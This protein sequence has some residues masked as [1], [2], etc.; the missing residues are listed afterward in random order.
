MPLTE[1]EVVVY[2]ATATGVTAAVAAAR[3]GASVTLVE[4]GRHVGGM[5]SGGLSWTD[6]GDVR[7][8]GGL[9]AEFH[10]AVADAYGVP[11]WGV[12][13]PEPHVAEALLTGWLDRAG[14][15]V[16][17][18]G[19]LNQVGVA[20]G[21]VVELTTVTDR[22]RASVFVDASYEGD[23]L[24]GAGVSY[25]IGR[26]PRQLYGERWAGRQP[27]TRP[28]AHN[29]PLVL[30]PFAEDGTPYPHVQPP[31]VDSRGWT[32]D[33]LGAGDGGLQA[34]AFRVCLTDRPDNR[35][36]FPEPTG[37]DRAEFGLLDA[38]LSAWGER[39]GAP[40]LLGV[41]RRLLPA[42]KCDVNSIGPFSLNVLDGSNRAYPDGDA[43]VRA[44]VRARHLHYTQS[45]LHHLS[46]ADTVPAHIRTEMATWGLCADEFGDT[47]G[48]PHQLYV[49]EGRR[50]LGEYVL[51]EADLVD[52]RRQ[53]DV[54]ALGSYNLDVREVRRSWVHLPE[55]VRREAVVNEGYLSVGVPIYP[56]PYRSLL[57]RR[58]ECRN[59]LVPL[60]LSASHVAF[61]S[62]RMEP[63]LMMLGQAA[64]TAAALTARQDTDVHDV[65]I[66]AVQD[67]LRA[68][69]QR[70]SPP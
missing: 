23:L 51:V 14:V 2:G 24:A 41:V 29:F 55:Y 11:L 16:V 4:A 53:P 19:P 37:Y 32:D 70:L 6:V 40:Q 46:H 45:L 39:I 1:D 27:P 21:R 43:A 33:A 49:R 50:I 17:L 8:I 65:D 5:V 18:D 64:G 15:N 42:G 12:R 22:H 20:D 36:P 10:Q 57:P 7:A 66:D 30:S 58:A 25:R 13:G 52:A 34:Y 56:I 47:G 60:C 44:R 38:Y 54:V 28:S 69:G 3:A 62:L 35:V 61:S 26:E 63:T 9:V 31:D 67:R 68:D 59:L 48:W